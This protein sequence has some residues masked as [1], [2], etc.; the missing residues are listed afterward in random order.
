MPSPTKLSILIT[1]CSSGGMGAA[2]AISFHNAGHRVFATARN[3]SKL[4]PLTSLGIETLPLDITSSSSIASAV[5]AIS[6]SLGT[7][8]LN[9]L[10]NNAAGSYTM[11]VADASLSSARALF[12]VNVWSQIAVTQA[13]IPLLL[14]A[15]AVPSSENHRPLPAHS[16]IVNHTSV[17]SMA[18]LPFQGIYN[19]SKAALAM[20]TST[21][22]MELAPFGITVID[23][24]TAGVKTNMITNNNVN[25]N[26]DRLP[27]GSI[28]EPARKV[29]E[30]A[31]SQDGLRDKGISADEWAGEVSGVLLGR[32]PPAE[33]WKGE[34]AR[35]VRVAVG[36]PGRV[37]EGAVKKMT[38]MDVVE[39]II[40]E[41][42]R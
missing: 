39:G 29:V 26:S 23:L 19:S 42:R 28:Y 13:F 21:L 30:E 14:L 20:L 34:G 2:L 11:P 5:T 18:A 24:K 4:S 32:D 12:D 3:P 8:G 37:F 31:M 27:E 38:K 36:M 10:I 7:A 16:M 1:G 15:T 40:K 6:S 41:G 35:L 25:S 17:G 22:R 9:M 33:I